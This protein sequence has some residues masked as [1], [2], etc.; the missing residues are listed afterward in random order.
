[1]GMAELIAKTVV[2]QSAEAVVVEEVSKRPLP[3][4][5]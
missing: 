2:K 1:M 4:R 3:G 5:L